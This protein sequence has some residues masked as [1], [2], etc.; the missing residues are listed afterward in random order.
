MSCGSDAFL[1]PPVGP[2]PVQ[3]SVQDEPVYGEVC[4]EVCRGVGAG[5]PV[6]GLYGAV[7]GEM[8]VYDTVSDL[9]CDH[10][11]FM[12]GHEGL[13]LVGILA[14]YL[15]DNGACR[16]SGQIGTMRHPVVGLGESVRGASA[17]HVGGQLVLRPGLGSGLGRV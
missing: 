3:R 4:Q 14:G 2:F 15:D 1:P 9:V 13:L 8:G 17:Q 12:F 11:V 10:I 16:E 5:Y 7:L 6:Y